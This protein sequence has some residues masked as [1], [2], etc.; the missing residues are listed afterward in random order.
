VV[1]ADCPLPTGRSL[2]SAQLAETALPFSSAIRED[3]LLDLLERGMSTDVA[4]LRLATHAGQRMLV[5]PEYTGP[6]AG[7]A[8][9]KEDIDRAKELIKVLG[10][11]VDSQSGV[12]KWLKKYEKTA[13]DSQD[14]SAD[15]GGPPPPLPSAKARECAPR[16]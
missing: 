1:A 11:T 2:R 3:E 12:L 7:K 5:F 9:L 10:K 6:E 4:R 13:S 15:P 16:Q 14:R 8:Q